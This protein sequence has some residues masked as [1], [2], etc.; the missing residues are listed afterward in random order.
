MSRSLAYTVKHI[1]KG[2]TLLDEDLVL[3]HLTPLLEEDENVDVVRHAAIGED[4]NAAEELDAHQKV[5]EPVLLLVVEEERLVRNPRHQVVALASL[6]DP[7]PPH[8][9]A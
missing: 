7:F 1:R 9:A 5:D 6:N 8:D 2:L 3:G 4:P